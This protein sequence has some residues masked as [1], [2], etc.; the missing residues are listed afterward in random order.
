MALLGPHASAVPKD[1]QTGDSAVFLES[2]TGLGDVQH[3]VE[4]VSSEQVGF[5]VSA[6][7]GGQS[8]VGTEDGHVVVG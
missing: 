7:R 6:P 5:G 2:A 3:R 4:A 1:L 8:R